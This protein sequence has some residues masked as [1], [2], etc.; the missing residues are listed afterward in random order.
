MKRF[1]RA[2]PFAISALL[3]GVLAG[4]APWGEVGHI[5]ADFDISTIIILVVLSLVYYALK[6]VRF[7]YLLQAMGIKQPLKI[8]ALS[9]MSAQPVTLL[10][11][12]ELYRSHSLEKHTGVPVKD[13]LP[14]FTTQGLLEGA[15]MATLSIFSAL[16]LGTLRLLVIGIAIIVLI[17]MIG[18][19]RGY[20]VNF[21]QFL[22]RL[23]FLH[24]KNSS[25]EQF[26]KQH[27]DI[28]SWHWLPLLYGIS[29]VIEGVGAGIAY[30]SVT[31]LGGHINAYQAILAYAVPIILG[32]VSLL[33][34]GFG[35]SE[36]S[37][38]GV[39]LLSDLKVATAVAATLVM[40]VTIVGLGVVYGGIAFLISRTH[41]K[42]LNFQ[43]LTNKV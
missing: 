31:G 36:Q 32:F 4:Y 8:V 23:P 20:L 5:F 26:S 22:N 18:I 29:L 33:P 30:A 37:A 10:P 9:Y 35:V 43:A 1:K 39:L 16:A 6:T 42:K 25:I 41:L 28:L 38:V 21:S 15:A 17:C 19:S 7:W 11:A 27:K 24:L 3:I 40:R 2:L 14:Q 34:G 13:S 12:G